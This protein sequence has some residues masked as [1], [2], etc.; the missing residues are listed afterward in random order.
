VG[1]DPGKTR[2]AGEAEWGAGRRQMLRGWRGAILRLIP[3]IYLIYVGGAVARYSHGAQVA[4]GFAVLAAFCACYVALVSLEASARATA[5]S[6]WLVSSLMLGLFA[7]ELPFAHAPAFVL[8]IYLTMIAV[9]RLGGR[10]A[11]IVIAL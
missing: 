8:G 2:A 1:V 7:A 5:R 3:L 9:A 6:F 10:A 11:P 4:G